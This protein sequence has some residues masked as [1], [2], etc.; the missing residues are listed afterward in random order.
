MPESSYLKSR[1]DLVTVGGVGRGEPKI[2]ENR[3]EGSGLNLAGK[4][5]TSPRYM[6]DITGTDPLCL[7]QLGMGG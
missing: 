4:I 6:T 7:G 3:V 2:F 1:P 5:S